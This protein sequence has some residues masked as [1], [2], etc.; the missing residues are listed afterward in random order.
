MNKVSS[1]PL[2]SVIIPFYNVEDYLGKCINSVITQ[3]YH[4]LEIILIDDGSNDSSSKIAAAYTK[5]DSR[6]K[7]IKQQ[8]GGISVA[9]NTGI[10]QAKGEYICFIDSDDYV[11]S[12]YI[13]ELF[14]LIQKYQVALSTTKHYIV[15]PKK[16][17]NAS[18]GK[19]E[20]LT[21]HD[22]FDK[23]LHGEDVDISAWGKLYHRSLFKTIRY[24]AGQNFEDTA[25]TYQLFQAAQT[26]ATK[27]IPTY[28]YIR[29]PNSITTGNFSE[30]MFELIAAT[31]QMTTDIS[32]WYPDLQKGCNRRRMFARLSTLTQL[33]KSAHPERKYIKP[34]MTYIQKHRAAILSDPRI[35]R[36]DRIALR[37][38]RFG[39][40]TYRIIW[41]IYQKGRES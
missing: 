41:N 10:D 2:I 23:L 12:N 26:V 15:Y 37:V 31:D 27:S 33:A 32:E 28:Y 39:F 34:L 17:I 7:T 30:K 36:R 22:L 29:R 11:A 18:T 20:L 6:I 5:K 25:T 21:T 4:N 35:P 24:P 9:R 8:N 1:Q 19:E 13:S 14:R 38:T 40:L 16:T 3:D